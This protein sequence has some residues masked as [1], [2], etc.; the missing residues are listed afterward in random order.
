MKYWYNVEIQMQG[1]NEYTKE[2][3][4]EIKE[5]MGFNGMDIDELDLHRM[6]ATFTSCYYPREINKIVDRLIADH[7]EI[8]Y[9]DF[10]YRSEIAPVQNRVVVWNDGRIQFY[11]G[12]VVFEEVCDK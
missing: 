5:T 9:I 10:L 7:P 3:N 4:K 6:T 8:Y 1:D 12:R 11:R 2:L